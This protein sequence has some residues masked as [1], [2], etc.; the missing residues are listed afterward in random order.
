MYSSNFFKHQMD[1][2]L[3]GYGKMGKAIEAEAIKRGHSIILKI[4]HNNLSALNE[5]NLQMADVAI[6]FTRPD[7]AFGNVWKCIEAG[8]PIVSGTTGWSDEME[9]ILPHCKE[10]EGS[11]LWASNFSVGVNVLFKVNEYLAKIMKSF[12]DYDINIKETHHTQKL[13]APSG[14][15]ITLAEAINKVHPI[16]NSWRLIEHEQEVGEN[17]IAI[18]AKRED[19]VPGTHEVN[20]K[21]EIDILTLEHTANNRRGFALGAILAAEYIHDKK[22]VFSMEDVLFKDEI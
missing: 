20:Y 2:A 21:S 12:P 16:Q 13:D 9:G 18:M 22:G 10:K 1:I 15:A 3:I 8:V 7:A 17:Q 4:D 19:D 14:T 11:F 5:S 6:E